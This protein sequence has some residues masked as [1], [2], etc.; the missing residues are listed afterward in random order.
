MFKRK[1]VKIAFVLACIMTLIMPYT[2]TVL[3]AVLTHSDETAELQVYVVHEGGAESSGTLNADQSE[4]Y[5][6]SPYGYSVGGTRV[7]KITTANSDNPYENMFYC[8]EANKSFPGVTNTGNTSLVYE[9]IANL[10]DSTDVNV[11]GLHLSTSFADDAEKWN[12][13]YKALIWLIDNMYLEK[14]APE[15][16]DDYLA[17]AFANYENHNLEMVK[18]FLTDDDID[19]VQQYAMWYFTNNDTDK[20]NVES[21]P[22]VELMKINMDTT[23]DEGTYNDLTGYTYRQDMASH[24]YSYLIESA[25]KAETTTVTYPSLITEFENVVVPEKEDY[26][27]VGPFKVIAGT[28]AATE[29]EIKLLD[30]DGNAINS[31]DYEILISGEEAFTEDSLNTIFGKEFFVYIPKINKTITKVNLELSYSDY[32]TEASLWEND[33]TNDSGEEVYQPVTLVTRKITPHKVNKIYDIDRRTEDLALRK[34]IIKVNDETVNRVPTVDVTG[35]KNGTSTTAVYKHAKN[36]VKVSNGDTVV[37]EIRVYNEADI[38]AKGTVIVDALPKGLELVEDSEI[39]NTYGWTK[40]AEGNNVVMYTTEYLKDTTIEAFDK[41]NDETLDSAYV[42]IE[43]KVSDAA[44]ASSVLTNIAEIR[45]DDIDDRDSTP[46]N[47]DYTKNDYDASGYTGDN[48]NKE[49]LTDSDYFYKGREDDD[50]FEKVEVE[51]KTFDLSLQKFITKINKMAPATSR[52]P[53]VDVTN[54]K[55]GTSTDAKYTTAKTPLVVEKGDIITYTIRVYNEG[56][57]AGYAE[58]VADYIPEGLGFLVGHTTNVA[59]YWAIPENSKTVKLNT[60]DNAVKNVSIDDFNDIESLQDVDVVVG[61]AKLVSTKLKSSATDTKNLIDG[62]DK[63]SDTEL[64]YK[65]IQVVCVVLTEEA[66]N[67]NFRNIAEVNKDSDKNREEVTDIDSNPD[68]VNPDN[69]PGDDQNQD[70]NDYENLTT[71]P[72]EFDL[73]LQKFISGVNDQAVTNR[74]PKVTV[75]N[76]KIVYSKQTGANDPLHVVNNDVV[77]YTIRVYNEGDIAGYASEISDNLPKGLEYIKNHSINE[78]YGWKLYDK[79]GNVTTDL[80]QAVSVKTDYLSK[81]KSEARNE[82]CLLD[83]FNPDSSKGPDYRDVKIAFKV[84]ENLAKGTAERTIRNIAEITDDE[85]ENGNPIDDVDSTPNNNKDGEDDIDDEKVYV[86][87][88]DL[89]LQKDLVKIIITENG[90][91][92]EIPVSSTDGLQKVEIHRK[93]VKTTT[94]KFVYNITVKNEGEIAGYATE[95]KD[96]IPQGL[97]FI[98]DENKQ[99]TKV[100]DN[101]ITT[102]AL[103][104]TKLE[105]GQTASVQVVLKWVNDENNLGSKINVAEI[106]ADKNDSNTPDIDSKPNNNIK[107]E[108]DIDDAEVILTISTG[109]AP[110]YIGLTFTVLAI[111]GTGIALIKKYV[112]I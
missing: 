90:T 33:T 56:E 45:T 70:D 6:I 44:K 82:D 35:L 71:D 83:P 59:N 64:A 8:L 95:I 2:T 93:R 46:D 74:E 98:A 43:C 69:Y 27:G 50:D 63:K 106:S 76:G 78:K 55:N 97:E 22:V 65:D 48:D 101:V 18:A 72:K 15:Q 17:K 61:K 16:K 107:G 75:S 102:N 37:Y 39:N 73:S 19:V 68:T 31:E 96:Y 112:L 11:K 110:T 77:I 12:A 91:T 86:K 62:F 34:Y 111:M 5:D 51:G 1:I 49:D 28:A 53:V 24:L 104:N 84:V 89:S 67:N 21:L 88:F 58:E 100:S 47:N 23:I 92:R 32:E 20:F 42:Q 108:D 3:A 29:Y 94:V 26:Y 14:Q 87:Y 41:A 10:K 99:W 9:N 81:E 40:M 109:S 85:D 54:L 30:Q 57:L 13:N 36:P 105:P 60:I 4:Y 38:D 80:T 103:A 79:N 7:Y 66:T 52:E 25:K